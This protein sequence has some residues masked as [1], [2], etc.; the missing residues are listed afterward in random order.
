MHIH[1]DDHL[2]GSGNIG[3]W[4]VYCKMRCT[5][6]LS[7][8][9]R[10]VHYCPLRITTIHYNSLLLTVANLG[11]AS[12]VV[13]GSLLLG[14]LLASVQQSRLDDL[15]LLPVGLDGAAALLGLAHAPPLLANAPRLP[16]RLGLPGP[17]PLVLLVLQLLR[18]SRTRLLRLSPRQLRLV[19]FPLCLPLAHLASACNAGCGPI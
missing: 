11:V 17:R 1:I 9:R 18:S 8:A 3:P 19:R 10:P 14:R 15:A 13:V 5:A 12:L 2:L 6:S 4:V 7:T 16:L